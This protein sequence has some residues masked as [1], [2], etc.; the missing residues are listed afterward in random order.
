MIYETKRFLLKPFI[1]EDISEDYL[2][3]F[4]SPEVTK[5]NSHGLGSFVKDD[6]EKYLENNPDN[7]I[8]GIWAKRET[9]VLKLKKS[10][11]IG[12]ISLQSINQTNKSAEMAIV[13]GNTDYWRMGYATE[14]LSILIDHGFKKM[15][16]HRIWTGTAATN[17]GMQR[18]AQKLGFKKEG[19]LK[20]G[21][22]LNGKYENVISY[23][24]LFGEWMNKEK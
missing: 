19:E 24:L 21:V 23:G 6:A 8:F 14:A 4:S 3:W 2:S 1:K 15:N 12:N 11:H 10:I 9:D 17:I 20:S 5:H 7:I 16:M 18:V 13:M 22:W